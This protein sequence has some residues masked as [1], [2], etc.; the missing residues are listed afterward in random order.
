MKVL[1]LKIPICN[2]DAKTGILCS[3]CQAKLSNGQVT[4]GDIQVSK[5]LTQYAEHSRELDSVVLIRSYNVGRD[6]L[7]EVN[8]PGIPILRKE[9]VRSEVERNLGGQ[10]WVTG[11]ARS[12]K[13]LI[14]DLLYPLAI[15]ELSTLWLPDGSKLS[16]VFVGQI[17]RRAAA[18]LDAVQ[19]LAKVARGIDL[20]VDY[21][22]FEGSRSRERV[23]DRIPI[24]WLGGVA[25]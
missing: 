8:E 7:V 25:G 23:E 20:L 18:R 12:N 14:E 5:A 2:F 10:L 9:S 1:Q 4:D 6:Y 24:T 19:K 11:T 22:T 17:G 21:E 13:R 15:S 3:I 16:K